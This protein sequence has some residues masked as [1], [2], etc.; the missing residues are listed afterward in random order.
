M[1]EGTA[2]G[3]KTKVVVENAQVSGGRRSGFMSKTSVETETTLRVLDARECSALCDVPDI[4]LM[5]E[6]E[7]RGL[8]EPRTL[9]EVM[10]TAY[11][12]AKE[13]EGD[14]SPRRL[15]MD[16]L[17]VAAYQV[18]GNVRGV[19]RNLGSST[20]TISRALKLPV[21]RG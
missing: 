8:M 10:K 14:S 21:R 3:Q 11:L 19:R 5:Q 13:Q 18:E 9:H 1:S 7:F 16:E 6:M 20:S 15:I 4:Y 12:L 17:I 2:I